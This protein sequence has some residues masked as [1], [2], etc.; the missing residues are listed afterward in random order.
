MSFAK[1]LIK[2][3]AQMKLY[4]YGAEVLEELTIMC[5]CEGVFIKRNQGKIVRI[6]VSFI[7]LILLL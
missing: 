5:E 4:S 3:M 6:K 1:F 2:D 7:T